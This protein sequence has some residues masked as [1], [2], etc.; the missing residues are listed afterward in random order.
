MKKG[1]KIAGIV[2]AALL[3][4]LLVL[5]LAFRGKIREVLVREGN[6]MLDGGFD[7]GAVN[8]SLIR[9]FPKATVSITDFSLWGSGDF[10]G[11][12]LAV[13]DR[14]S[15][16]V[17][18]GSIFSADGFDVSRVLVDDADIHAVVL[19]DGRPNWDILK[20]SDTPETPRDTT[21]GEPPAFRVRLRKLTLE[22]L[23]VVFDDRAS[24]MYAAVENFSTTA[25][26]DLGAARTTL[27]IRSQI[28][29]LTFRYGGIPYLSGATVALQAAVDADLENMQFTLSD[30]LLSLNALQAGLEG[31][32]GM[33]EQGVYDLDV[34]LKTEQI[35]F[36]EILSMIPAIYAKD[37]AGLEASGSVALSA[38]ARGRMAGDD[39]P[40]FEA[41]L[42]VTDGRF[43]YPSL[44]KSVD[45][46]RIAASAK[47]PGGS[48]DATTL[49]V[50][51]LQFSLAGNP[52]AATLDL[53][54]PLSD[55]AFAV[56]AE[57][58]LDLGMIR[59]VYPLDSIELNGVL[60][61]D[62]DLK[63][64]LSYVD[65]GAYDRFQASGMLQIR[66]MLVKMSDMPDVSIDRSLF[67]FTPAYLQLSETRVGI[68]RSDVTVD[69]RLQNYMAFA[70]RGET[71][72]GNL[73]VR[74]GLL[75][76]NEL[77]GQGETTSETLAADPQASP[78]P[79]FEVPKNIDFD[80]NVALQKVYF[81]NL[82]LDEVAGRVSVADGK[83]DMSNLS[84]R[85]LQGSVVA[86][87]SYSTA[88][89]PKRPEL[90]ASFDM[91]GLSFSETFQKFVT[92]Q[93][94]VPIFEGL[95]GNFSGQA[96]IRARMD[97]LMNVD[98][99]SLAGE[100]LLRTGDVT[101]SGIR[102]LD[103]IAD[104]VNR[105]ELK[106]I[107][108]NDLE[109]PFTIAGGRVS[110]RP[111]DLRIGSDMNLNL[112]GST[113]IDQTIDYTGRLR[114]PASAG[115]ASTLTT[116]DLRIGGTFTAPTVSVDMAGMARQAVEN[117]TEQATGEALSRV[118]E[119]LGIDISNA[120]SQR[121]ALIE[122]AT[123]AGARLVEE[124]Q[125][126]A[127]NLVAEAGSNII[128]STGAKLAGRKLVEQ[129]QQQA[130][131]LI[132]KAT[133]EG[134]KLVERARAGEE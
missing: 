35:G 110:T 70:L 98:Y 9:N 107:R 86:N 59:E 32:F 43:R 58:T 6:K 111:F 130:D 78:T 24:K 84:L 123:A 2:I 74:S 25:S 101:L 68:G 119:A 45:N 1:L 48:A 85:T 105:P 13:I 129:A 95:H 42:E 23:D 11:D 109:L 72:R 47:N 49:S 88:D 40:A 134:D 14:M 103:A 83:L 77:T 28:E 121:A 18:L 64:R 30:N 106:N 131:N 61:A 133:E 91:S 76:L 10:A 38:W 75:D 65:L 16:T 100:G 37:F 114:L 127:D 7:V 80:M 57:G 69:S 81:T 12:T 89:D 102:A 104:A 33:P 124:A 87:G 15:L 54:T 60:T 93:K 34:R 97:S 99:A 29:A 96:R 55:P 120:E 82:E 19:E 8:I 66:D 113:G 73:N 50:Q 122:Q 126:Q 26:G 62:L 17:N 41:S 46:I 4:L 44:P 118:G 71:I 116:L 56:T 67:T 20:P 115:I 112:S 3:V 79:A 63:G 5:P 92:I 90:D 51:P 108:A 52:F 21:S 53:A 125:R 36:K 27:R 39:L 22:N 94:L 128:A 117:L 132:A 31:T